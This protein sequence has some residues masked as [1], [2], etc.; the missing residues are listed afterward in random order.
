M[1]ACWT[2]QAYNIYVIAENSIGEDWSGAF[3]EKGQ[4]VQKQDEAMVPSQWAFILPQGIGGTS[5]GS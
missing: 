3:L 1:A 5:A 2:L 4:D